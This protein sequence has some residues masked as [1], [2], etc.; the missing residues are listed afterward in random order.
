M[1]RFKYLALSRSGEKISGLIEA[2][3]EMDAAIRVKERANVVLKLT[4]VREKGP[5]FLNL[6]LGASKLDVKAFTL[7]C[8]QFST[9]LRSGV[10]ISRAVHLIS[11][12][13]TDKQLKHML[14]EIAEDVEG[15]RTLSAAFEDHGGKLLPPTF[16][17]TLRSGEESGSLDRSFRTVQEQMEKQTVTRA[18]VKSAMAYPVFVMVIAVVVVAVVMTVVIPR[19]TP[20]FTESDNPIPFML[21]TLIAA[22]DF[23]Q[24]YIVLIVIVIALAVLGLKLYGNTENGRLRLAR[25][26][27]HLPVLGNIELLTAASEFA[28]SMTALMTAGL[29]I[30]KSI[31]ITSKTITNYYLSTETG[32][33]SGEL[34][35]GRSLTAA[36]RDQKV[37]PDILV[38]MVGVGEE[39]GELT[40]TLRTISEFYETELN[41]ATKAAIS[42]L[43][44]AMLIF[45]AIFA[46]YIVMAIYTGIFS[47]YGNM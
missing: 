26:K 5:G 46:G 25:L 29:S 12:R 15:G 31:N 16:V 47:M 9:I 17:E 24:H 44:P 14:E 43:E 35:A 10:P 30:P 38:D 37:M 3:N 2:Y 39:T 27:L 22:S 11:D 42:K 23:F 18:K 33:L 7:M 8:N 28:S 40:E 21:G 32:K 34:E 1:A 6:E 41:E 19:L 13:T 45:I 36:M 20:I 4:P